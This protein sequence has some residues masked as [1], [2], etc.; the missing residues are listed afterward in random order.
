MYLT[1]VNKL[2]AEMREETIERCAWF[3]EGIGTEGTKYI[4]DALRA[5]ATAPMGGTSAKTQQ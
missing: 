1:D 5:L 4:A 2:R 3:V